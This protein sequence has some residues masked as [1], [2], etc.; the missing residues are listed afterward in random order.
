MFKLAEEKMDEDGK[1]RIAPA[2]KSTRVGETFLFVGL[3]G[4]VLLLVALIWQ[5]GLPTDFQSLGSPFLK[6]LAI[7]LL[8]AAIVGH[9]LDLRMNRNFLAELAKYIDS[10]EPLET[11]MTTATSNLAEES[12]KLVAMSSTISR[13]SGEMSDATAML[14]QS[15]KVLNMA[16]EAGI[17]QVLMRRTTHEHTESWFKAVST[18]LADELAIE[19]GEI[20]IACVAAPDIMRGDK[21]G[22]EFWRAF[23]NRGCT[24][25]LR[26][27]LLEPECDW[28]DK[29][30]ETEVNHPTRQD[31]VGA[32]G[33]LEQKKTVP[34]LADRISFRTSDELPSA[35]LIVTSRYVFLEPYPRAKPLDLGGTLGPIGGI[36]PMMV[37][38]AH[39]PGYQRWVAHFEDLWKESESTVSAQT[40]RDVH[41][42]VASHLVKGH[43]G[44]ETAR[45]LTCSPAQF[46][47][48]VGRSPRRFEAAYKE[49]IDSRPLA[50]K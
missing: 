20:R 48:A 19:E 2:L 35:F 31:I 27:V 33:I 38:A 26:M 4:V 21:A 15:S 29:R 39:S 32:L 47:R 16:I 5:H 37:L 14:L 41:R 45:L 11:K 6:E 8:I 42:E 30:S 23:E 7:A 1:R 18:A 36:T 49:V 9:A 10:L 3:L 40:V 43:L 28:L 44:D 13:L 50:E 46:A 12:H 24:A 22:G 25:K 17:D 34:R